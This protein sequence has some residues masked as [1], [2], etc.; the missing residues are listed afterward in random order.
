MHRSAERTFNGRSVVIIGAGIFGAGA[1]V[2]LISRGYK[3]TLISPN[4]VETSELAASTD[5][6]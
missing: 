4:G 3:V 5:I 1:A 6:R 2:E